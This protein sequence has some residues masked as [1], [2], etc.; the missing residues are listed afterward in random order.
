MR[1]RGWRNVRSTVR[2][3]HNEK[4]LIQDNINDHLSITIFLLTMFRLPHMLRQSLKIVSVVNNLEEGEQIYVTVHSCWCRC[5]K[6]HR[7]VHLKLLK[8]QLPFLS[9]FLFLLCVFSSCYFNRALVSYSF[10][11][12]FDFRGYY[13]A[14]YFSSYSLISKHNIV[15]FVFGVFTSN[16]EGF[17]TVL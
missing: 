5:F 6:M 10:L 12:S 3:E 1:F 16:S 2:K 9:N 13:V 17:C 14:C 8:L 7:K 11:D 4:N 15:N